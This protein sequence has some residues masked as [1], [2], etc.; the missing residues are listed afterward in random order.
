MLSKK[1]KPVSVPETHHSTMRTPSDSNL[2]KTPLFTQQVLQLQHSIGNRATLQ[3]MRGAASTVSA[4]KVSPNHIQR[5][6]QPGTQIELA[7]AGWGTVV[8]INS[9]STYTMQW[10]SPI[11][12]QFPAMFPPQIRED[13]TRIRQVV[14]P[15]EQPLSIPPELKKESK[16]VFEEGEKEKEKE[17]EKV[18]P[19]DR[20][21]NN[22]RKTEFESKLA[23]YL[24]QS[25][26]VLAVVGQV[27]NII[28]EMFSSLLYQKPAESE[29]KQRRRAVHGGEMMQATDQASQFLYSKGGTF[30]AIEQNK[31]EKGNTVM[32]DVAATLSGEND[33]GSMMLAQ[34]S[35]LFNVLLDNDAGQ[36]AGEFMDAYKPREEQ[37][38]RNKDAKA[39]DTRGKYTSTGIMEDTAKG[40]G[41]TKE[42]EIKMQPHTRTQE[43]TRPDED[44]SVVQEMRQLDMPF[45]GGLSGSA[46][47][48]LALAHVAELGGDD[49]RLYVLAI[50]G[51]L[52][53]GGMH[54]IHEIM[55]VASQKGIDVPYTPGDYNSIFPERFRKTAQY[56]LLADEFPDLIT[57]SPTIA[58]PFVRKRV[59]PPPQPSS[60]NINN[61]GQ[62]STGGGWVSARPRNNNQ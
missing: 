28:L 15:G 17:E 2:N 30:G 55:T 27:S 47:D 38:G 45:V 5:E 42:F 22:I 39:R 29:K 1:S 21:G 12:Q 6:F 20:Y 58:L 31:P 48:L 51:Y 54:S 61:G 3:L 60:A 10:N 18:V 41:L 46:I 9:D 14:A 26:P 56:L 7:G 8:A 34:Q 57:V 37:R 19:S 23:A 62:Q 24:T 44:H 13:D 4:G 49:L 36:Q 16:E 40:E 50:I 53:G 35:F 32:L 33:L 25:G 52:V 11:A 43:S 59:N